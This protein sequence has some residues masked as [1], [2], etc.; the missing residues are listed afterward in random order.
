MVLGVLVVF[1]DEVFGERN[2][3]AELS[4]GQ[5]TFDLASDPLF[6][7]LEATHRCLQLL[8]IRRGNGALH[9]RPEACRRPAG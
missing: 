7:I 5:E 6:V 3:Q 8:V 9:I 1:L 2:R 4:I